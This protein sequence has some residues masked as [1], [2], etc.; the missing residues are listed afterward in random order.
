MA[1][2]WVS[3]SIAA[4]IV[5]VS[6]WALASRMRR[7]IKKDLNRTAESADLASLETWMKVDEAEEKKE[8]GREWVPTSIDLGPDTGARI[9]LFPEDK[10]SGSRQ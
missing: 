3:G 10:K 8:P 2:Y 4:V 5:I 7:R 9:D 6:G 1:F